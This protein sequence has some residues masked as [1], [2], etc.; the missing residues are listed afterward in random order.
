MK[1]PHVENYLTQDIYISPQS[2]QPAEVSE[3]GTLEMLKGESSSIDKYSITF[4]DFNIMNHGEDEMVVAAVLQVSYDGRSEEITPALRVVEGTVSSE[5]ASFDSETGT[6]SIAGVNPEDGGVVL[7]FAGAFVPEAGI[8]KASIM[9]ELSRKPLILLFWLGT[10]IMFGGGILSLVVRKRRLRS[11]REK[12]R[13]SF[14][15]SQTASSS[16]TERV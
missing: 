12:P 8:G 5:S 16:I 3:S 11:S 14:Q 13:E 10:I 1:K 4:S 7:N 15:G 2:F 6:V 9:I